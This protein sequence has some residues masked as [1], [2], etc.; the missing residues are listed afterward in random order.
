M[1][2]I[3]IPYGGKVWWGKVW[4]GKVWRNDSFQAFGEGKFGELIEQPIDY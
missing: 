4:Q 1:L 2:H 3:R